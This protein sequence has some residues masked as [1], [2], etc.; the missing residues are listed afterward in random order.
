MIFYMSSL[1]LRLTTMEK[2][3][4]LDKDKWEQIRKDNY[5]KLDDGYLRLDLELISTL[6]SGLIEKLLKKLK[7]IV[8]LLNKII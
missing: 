8:P 2:S 4:T 1:A 5:L 6:D 3:E 7:E